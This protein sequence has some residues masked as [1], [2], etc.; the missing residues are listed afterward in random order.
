MVG[1]Y[2][3]LQLRRNDIIMAKT[4]IGQCALCRQN[5]KLKLSHIVPNFVGRRLKN[6][7]PGSIRVT[8]EPNKVA[9]DIEKHFMLCHDCEELFSARERWFANIFFNPYQDINETIYDY[10]ENLTYFIVSLSWRSLYLDLTEYVMD[11][12]FDQDILMTLFRAEE[13]MHDYLMGKRADIGFIENHIFFLDRIQSISNMDA[14]KNPSLAMHRSISSY[15]AYNGATSFTI[16]NLMGILIVTFYSMHSKEKWINTKINLGI[17]RIEAR[18]QNITSVVGKEIQH[19]MNQSEEAKNNL[20]PI[21][22]KK[23]EEKFKNIGEDI[24]KYPIYQDFEDDK[25]LC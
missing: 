2:K 12:D 1:I 20:S 8:N 24:K 6:T 25:N 7:S 22:K 11:T 16:S 10:N 13:I 17:G 4:Q 15:T 18:N 5:K 19:W 9:Q 3:L 14:S 21:Q 23:I